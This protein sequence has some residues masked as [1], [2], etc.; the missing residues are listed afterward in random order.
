MREQQADT[1]LWDSWQHRNRNVLLLEVIFPHK[2]QLG[3][4]PGWFFLEILPVP[5]N[6]DYN[7]ITDTLPN[8]A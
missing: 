7:I 5:A 2:N 8:A 4:R 3:K 6:L 1:Y